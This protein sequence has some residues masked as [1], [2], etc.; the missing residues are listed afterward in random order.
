MLATKVQPDPRLG[1]KV[2]YY[3]E[4]WRCGIIKSISKVTAMIKPLGPKKRNV[5]IPIE[6]IDFETKI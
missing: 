5:M 1:T 3:H 6:D 4:G 2:R